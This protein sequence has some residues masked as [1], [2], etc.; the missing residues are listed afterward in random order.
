MQT[1]SLCILINQ[2]NLYLQLRNTGLESFMCYHK[3]AKIL[4]TVHISW[5]KKKVHCEEVKPKSKPRKTDCTKLNVTYFVAGIWIF[6]RMIL[7]GEFTIS[8]LNFTRGSRRIYAKSFWKKNQGSNSTFLLQLPLTR[9]V[10]MR[11][12]GPEH[13]RRIIILTIST[14]RTKILEENNTKLTK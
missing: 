14:L 10:V 4:N 5:L 6:I 1:K 8:F 2:Q 12:C 11:P 7:Q 9:S 3:I 13:T